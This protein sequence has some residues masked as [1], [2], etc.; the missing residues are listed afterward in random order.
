MSCVWVL[1]E[2]GGGGLSVAMDVIWRRLC[3]SMI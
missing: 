3:V 1:Q 2:W